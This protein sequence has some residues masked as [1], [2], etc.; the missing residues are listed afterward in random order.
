MEV[1][2]SSNTHVA[3]SAPG[4]P[5]RHRRRHLRRCGAAAA[6][7]N[8]PLCHSGA[9]RAPSVC[10]S[11]DCHSPHSH[12]SV[13][14]PQAPSVAASSAG[15]VQH[16]ATLGHVGAGGVI[17]VVAACCSAPPKVPTPVRLPG[18]LGSPIVARPDSPHYPP[19]VPASAQSLAR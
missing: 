11:T 18:T 4:A 12:C 7:R 1:I 13:S 5:T 2:Y 16:A 9:C 3:P 15:P 19:K 8:S 17:L 14:P 6:H 10:V